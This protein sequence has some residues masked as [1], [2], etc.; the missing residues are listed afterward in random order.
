[1]KPRRTGVLVPFNPPKARA[2]PRNRARRHF[3]MMTTT[4]SPRKPRFSIPRRPKPRRDP[5][6]PGRAD[7]ELGRRNV[8]PRPRSVLEGC[9]SGGPPRASPAGRPHAERGP[10]PTLRRLPRSRQAA[11]RV[12]PPLVPTTVG[13]PQDRGQRLPG[14]LRILAL[15][16]VRQGVIAER[17]DHSLGRP[18]RRGHQPLHMG[19]AG[20][21]QDV[22]DQQRPDQVLRENLGRPATVAGIAEVGFQAQTVPRSLLVREWRPRN[23]IGPGFPWRQVIREFGR[24]KLLGAPKLLAVGWSQLHSHHVSFATSAM[25]RFW[26]CSSRVYQPNSGRVTSAPR[27][28]MR[29]NQG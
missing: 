6:P 10:W 28:W 17:A 1:M 27:L 18:G 15:G 9:L 20:R 22:V 7:R 8:P 16:E 14:R 19:K 23:R 29:E 24:W 26:F 3:L 13:R 4:S 21:P 2:S 25:R 5:F 11:A 12:E